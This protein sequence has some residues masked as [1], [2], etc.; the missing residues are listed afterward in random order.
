MFM[1]IQEVADYYG[2]HINTIRRW[3]DEAMSKK[4]TFPLP[5]TPP[6][7]KRMWRR[8]DIENWDANSDKQ[9]ESAVA[10]AVRRAQTRS[11]L[12]RHGVI[13]K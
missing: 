11:I 1:T 13:N 10:H 6:R 9:E 7:K 8:V 12:L 4:S 5:I 3:M 2:K